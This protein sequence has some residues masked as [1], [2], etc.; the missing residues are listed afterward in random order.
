MFHWKT[1]VVAFSAVGVIGLALP[2]VA[3]TSEPGVAASDVAT[4]EEVIVTAQQ[5]SQT[6]RQVP[7]ALSVVGQTA[8]TQR[9]IETFG[10]LAAFVPGLTV[11]SKSAAD[12][13]LVLRG[14]SN[15]DG[16][17]YQ[18]PRVSVFQ[19]GTPMSKAR[20]A[21]VELFDLERVEVARGPQ[22][23]LF[24]RNALTGA[25]N[26]IQHKADPVFEAMLGGEW[27]SRGHSL[28][29]GVVN[30]PV[31]DTL[32]IRLV[33]R[34]REEGGP[35]ANLLEGGRYGS[36]R[37]EAGRLTVSW[38]PDPAFGSHLILNTEH[39][40]GSGQ[41]FK[42]AT[43]RPSIAATGD[44]VGSLSVF[45]GATLAAGAGF[46]AG[47]G[48]GLDRRLDSAAWLNS[49][50]IAPGLVLT[51]TTA[52]RRFK[53]YEAYDF[54]GFVLP[55]LTVGDDS[56]GRQT[57]QEFRVNYDPS[58]K[59]SVVGGLSLIR[60]N[61]A[62]RI[63]LQLDERLVLALLTGRLDRR[64]PVL[65]PEAA[66]TDRTVVAG[67]LRG[68]ALARGAALSQ[69]QALAIADN[70]R[71]DHREVYEDA[72]KSKGADL[73][74]DLAWA[75]IERLQLTAGIRYGWLDR[76]SGLSSAVEGRSVL[77]GFL[78]ALS[79]PAAQR[80]ALLGALAFPG[81][82]TL[83]R[84]TAYPIP[85]F[86]LRAQPTP[87]G[88]Q[89][90]ADFQDE[91]AAWRLVARYTLSDTS[92]LYASYARGRRPALLS[93]DT[94]ARPEGDVV[95]TPVAAETIDSYEVGAKSDWPD[96]KLRAGVAVYRYDYRHF[97]TVT[98]QGAVFVVSDAGQASATGLE[99]DVRWAPTRGVETFGLLD[100]SHARFEDGL[101][102]G[103]RLALNSDVKVTVGA[104][105][106]WTVSGGALAFTPSYAWRSALFFSDDNGIAALATGAFVTP[107]DYRPRQDG[108]GL[109][110]A[111][112][113]FTPVTGHWS[114]G[115]FVRNALDEKFLTDA[116]NGGEDFGLP[117]YTRGDRR[118]VGL[119]VSLRR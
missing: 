104:N 6:E 37:V 36:S 95:F 74:A 110:N 13:T 52:V 92:T 32:S 81:A 69:T 18:E 50:T 35:S 44:A 109:L 115:V 48:L 10:D 84:S 59:I 87:G 100:L 21:F 53:S 73:Y 40:T 79:Q 106:R 94:P 31:A 28:V 49:W 11:Q 93:P 98:Q 61:G 66:Y 113:D 55:L 38:R 4:L 114:V 20:G 96:L 17:S 102:K 68:L 42:S 82:A 8:M 72:S 75:P 1:G 30:A 85:L 80:Q 16:S 58:S 26:L 64:N 107:L 5:R 12:S 19:D 99:A 71:G 119:R 70:L 91:G 60:E 54:D 97:Q 9:R 76:T 2:A 117:T 83:P 63:P 111:T 112:L 57:T 27:G 86:G 103:N 77:A 14:I 22:T 39:T 29:E 116:G 15:A 89:Q 43:F 65:A 105:L 67:Q 45:T 101:Y 46:D 56:F 34:V 78:G 108:Y 88:A 51:S 90:S 62:Q 3:Q 33:G 25:I 23:T 24:G 7:M 41:P 47:R 118:L